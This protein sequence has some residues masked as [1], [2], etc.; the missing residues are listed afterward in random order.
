MVSGEAAQG[1]GQWSGAGGGAADRP[2]RHVLLANP[3]R[4]TVA[5]DNPDVL[6]PYVSFCCSDNPDVLVPYVSFCCSD[7]P[8]VLVPYVS[9]CCSDVSFCCSDVSFCCSVASLV[10]ICGCFLVVIGFA[11]DTPH[12]IVALI[13]AIWHS[14]RKPTCARCIQTAR[15]TNQLLAGRTWSCGRNTWS[16][17]LELLAEATVC[18]WGGGLWALNRVLHRPLGC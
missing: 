18:V 3:T 10:C 5:S 1:R 12:L 8:D 15:F 4:V 2:C 11:Y 17:L 7:N 16:L 14:S 13:G 6:V 9:F